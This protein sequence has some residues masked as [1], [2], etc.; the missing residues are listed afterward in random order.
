MP[1]ESNASCLFCKILSGQI[2]SLLVFEDDVS[3]AFLDHRPVFPGHILLI[4][5]AHHETL[6]DLPADLVGVFFANAQLLARA[7]ELSVAAEG[8]FVAINNRVSQSVPHLHVHIVPRRRKDGLKGFFWPRHP[9]KNET[10]AIEIQCAV[11]KA[12]MALIA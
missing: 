7:V 8:T 11:R 2:G 10:D 9:Y 1:A 5:K 6:T 4:P 3:L 12:V